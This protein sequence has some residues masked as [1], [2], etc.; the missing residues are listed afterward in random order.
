MTLRRLFPL[1][2]TLVLGQALALGTL[3]LLACGQS[4]IASE[5]AIAQQQQPVTS[6]AGS[7]PNT[8]APAAAPPVRPTNS[9]A[10]QKSIQPSVEKAPRVLYRGCELVQTP[11]D[12]PLCLPSARSRTLFWVEGQPCEKL[13]VVEDGKV[14]P[15]LAA[16]VQGGCQLKQQGPSNALRSTLTLRYRDAGATL[17][18]MPV[19]RSRPQSTG[20]T[21]RMWSRSPQDLAAAPDELKAASIREQEPIAKLDLQFARGVA[22]RRMGDYEHAL[23]AFREVMESAAR[24]GIN[25]LA[26]RAAN[27][28]IDMLILLG[29]PEEAK[30]VFDDAA[31]VVTS[32]Y[33][34]DQMVRARDGGEIARELGQLA[35]SAEWFQKARIVAEQIGDSDARYAIV[36]SLIGVLVK[37]DRLQD[38]QSLLPIMIQQLSEVDICD[39]VDP[40]VLLGTVYLN[41][42][43]QSSS[44]DRQLADSLSWLRR[45]QDANR[46]CP[47]ANKRAEIRLALAQI[48]LLQ[49]RVSDAAAELE[50]VGK[51]AGIPFASQLQ[52]LDLNAQVALRNQR[53][54]DAQAFLNQLEQFARQRSNADAAFYQ[55]K[56]AVAALAAHPTDESLSGTKLR[57]CIGPE[58]NLAPLERNYLTR[59]LQAAG[60][61]P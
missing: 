55:C 3:G 17:W 54:A 37:L 41:W 51:Q 31:A 6:P 14:L 23:L 44:T 35:E 11:P 39:Q 56:L 34:W 60:V 29:L 22:L 48:A 58:S 47:R 26:F 53:P 61:S 27:Q 5:P 57:K 19:D 13:E 32:G 28:C 36:S 50:A 46:A 4:D 12:G 18:S 52:L 1:R 8:Q 38:V 33:G 42:A 43:E 20:V 25:T 7:N 9:G 24:L 2:M 16:S 49:D 30:L 21:Q 45:A 10:L 40:L 15:F 59:R